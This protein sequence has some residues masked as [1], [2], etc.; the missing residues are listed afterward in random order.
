M[1]RVFASLNLVGAYGRS[2]GGSKKMNIVGVALLMVALLCVVGQSVSG[3]PLQQADQLLQ[4]V[5]KAD[6]VEL[7]G[8]GVSRKYQVNAIL[9][10]PAV[11]AI[12]GTALDDRYFTILFYQGSMEIGINGPANNN[13]KGAYSVANGKLTVTITNE[14]S[15]TFDY[16]LAGERLYL[17]YAIQGMQLS[18]V[19][20]LDVKF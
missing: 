15:R 16:R 2:P 9:Q 8:S 10:S 1:T 3:K 13:V 7:T 6:S 4:G 17:S 11:K 5:W 20:K 14:T 19:F 12:F 18:M